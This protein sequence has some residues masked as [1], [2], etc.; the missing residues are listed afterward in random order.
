MPIIIDGSHNEC[1]ID[2]LFWQVEAV[3]RFCKILMK[4]CF[5]S[6]VSMEK[7]RMDHAVFGSRI[8]QNQLISFC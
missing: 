2:S 6:K 5:F 8:S 7:K 3:I 1:K 4:G